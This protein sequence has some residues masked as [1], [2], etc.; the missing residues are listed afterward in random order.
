[1]TWDYSR[2]KGKIKEVYNTQDNF[3]EALGM[4]RTSLSQ[5]LNNQLEFSQ[6]EIAKAMNLLGEDESNMVAFFYTPEVQKH[7]RD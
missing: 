3:A 7:E 4:S 5:R 6:N 1:M 2:L